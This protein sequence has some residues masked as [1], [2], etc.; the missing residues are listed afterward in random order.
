MDKN[1][2]IL[3]AEPRRRTAPPR[4][5]RH[6]YGDQLLCLLALTGMAVWMSGPR[7]VSLAAVAVLTS[8]LVDMICCRLSRKVYNPRDLSTVCSGLCLALMSPV[9]LNYLMMVFGCAL[10]IGV[11]HIFGGKDNYIFNP[12]AVAFAFLIIC[13]PAKMLLF[14]K[15]GEIPALLGESVITPT[16]GLESTLLKS[17]AFSS[18]APLD[19][20]IGN[21]S[22]PVGTTHV[23]ILL[24]CA[25]CLMFRRSVSPIVMIS[26]V[27]VI[28]IFRLLF[29]D[30]DDIIGALAVE[31]VGGYFLFALIFLANDPQTLPKTV[32]GKLYYGVL[33]GVFSIVFRG[34]VEGCFIFALLAANTFAARMDIIAEKAAADT[35]RFIDAFKAR[36][37]AYERFSRDAKTGKT[38]ELSATQEI[39]INPTNYDMPPINNKVIKINRKRRNVLAFVIEKVGSLREKTKRRK[40]FPVSY[41]DAT[42]K[43]PVFIASAFKALYESSAKTAREIIGLFSKK[44]P[45]DAGDAKEDS[46]K[47]DGAPDNADALEKPADIEKDSGIEITDFEEIADDIAKIE[48][49]IESGNVTDA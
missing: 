11:K 7:S 39:I 44:Q 10:A 21:F 34:N 26:C 49:A 1:T 19:A 18:L 6:I 17:G 27:S 20:L 30:Y 15:V 35:G 16:P 4:K 45:E 40:N 29:P 23:L 47:T 37:S 48:A 42:E 46:L 14:P 22:G 41:T 2:D 36:L 43:N 8:V 38:P 32:F 24:V 25:V 5:P 13:Y 3:D 33:L 9:T 28:T 12:P 31:F